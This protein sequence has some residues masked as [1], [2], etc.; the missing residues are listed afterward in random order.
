QILF[1]NFI[2]LYTKQLVLGLTAFFIP[3]FQIGVMKWCL[4]ELFTKIIGA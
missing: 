3:K 1:H 2:S 4:L